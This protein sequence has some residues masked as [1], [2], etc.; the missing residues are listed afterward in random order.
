MKN[1]YLPHRKRVKIDQ[2]LQPLH[3]RTHTHTHTQ[4]ISG[5]LERNEEMTFSRELHLSPW[6]TVSGD[7]WLGTD[8]LSVSSHS[9]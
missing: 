7:R 1:I 5:L 2:A 6:P 4:T 3:I 9:G 8:P